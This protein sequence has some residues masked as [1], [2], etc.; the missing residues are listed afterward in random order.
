[1]TA[2]SLQQ[3]AE[4]FADDLTR[5]VQAV[6]P[7][8]QPFRVV[9]AAT[10]KG[11]RLLIRQEP[12]VGVPLAGE[13]VLL[14]TLKVDYWCTRDSHNDYLA[15]EHSAVKVYA[16]SAEGEPLFRYEYEHDVVGDIPRAHI[17]IHAHRDRHHLRHEPHRS[18]HQERRTSSQG[19]HRAVH[20]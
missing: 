8:C 20:A 1:M 10:A 7:G 9:A 2:S 14:L 11:D 15:V 12:D 4:E 19:Q 5:T 17:Q 13:G 16:G 18:R 3:Q 6:A